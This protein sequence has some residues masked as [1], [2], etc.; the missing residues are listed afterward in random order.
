MRRLVG[1]LAFV[2]TVVAACGRGERPAQQAAA[3]P[4][5]PAAGNAQLDPQSADMRV[6][7]PATYRARF[8]TS[9]GAFTIEVTRA[10]APGGADRFY[11][12]VRHGFFDGTRF[13]RVLPGFVVQFGL[14]ADPAVSA[15]W[16]AATI[17]DDPVLQHNLRGTIT[18]ATAGPNTRTTQLFLNYADNT[19][20]DGQGFSPFGRVV[21]GMGVVDRIYAGYGEQP[22]QGMI[23]TRGNAYLAAQF[24]RLDSIAKATI[25]TP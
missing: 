1:V 5:T 2:V 18:F 10:W 8:E 16:H 15:R 3:T 19:N 4:G 6:N 13:F 17:P 21:D 24:P 23:E 11:N 22:D 25:V 20:L 12:L 9:A 7:A 14:S